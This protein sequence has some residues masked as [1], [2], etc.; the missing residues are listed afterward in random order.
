VLSKIQNSWTGRIWK[1]GWTVSKRMWF[2]ALDHCICSI[3]ACV[4]LHQN[5]WLVLTSIATM[6]GKKQLD[7]FLIFTNFKCT[8][9]I[10]YTNDSGGAGGDEGG[11]AML[12]M[13]KRWKQYLTVCNTTKRPCLPWPESSWS[14]FGNFGLPQSKI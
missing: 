5:R 11:M 7:L 3:H 12:R 8:K 10:K 2:L 4:Y 9:D 13:L 1:R 6:N 14:V